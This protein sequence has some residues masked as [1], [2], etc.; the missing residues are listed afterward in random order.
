MTTQRPRCA[1][2]GAV[3]LRRQILRATP[4]RTTARARRTKK[5]SS[6]GTG[7]VLIAVAGEPG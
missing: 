2:G 5:S 7:G 6:A 1:K 3:G 4:Q